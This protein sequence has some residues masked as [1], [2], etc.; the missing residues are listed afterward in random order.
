MFKKFDGEPEIVAGVDLS[1]PSRKEGLAVIA[2]FEYPSMKMLK[3]VF[4]RVE[5]NFPYIPGLLSFRE[6]PAFLEAW[7]KL[8]L[9]PDVVVFDG[10]GIAHPRGIGI[11]AHMGL[12]IG[13]PT[14]GV[15]KSHL[16]GWYEELPDEEWARSPLKDK[17][18]NIIG[19]VV[20][21]KVGSKPIYVSPGN[22]IDVESSYELIKNMTIPGK[23]IPEPTRVADAL[24]KK[25]KKGT[26]L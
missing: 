25:L 18:G 16:Y 23:R 22:L 14:I 20:R 17:A 1:F 7:E 4:E 12:F 11:A 5:I 21:T 13:I 9:K 26:V 6:G 8:D 10:Q 24:T 2:I 15:A 19:Y 3:Y